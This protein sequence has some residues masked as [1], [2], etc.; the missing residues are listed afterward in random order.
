MLLSRPYSHTTTRTVSYERQSLQRFGHHS[1]TGQQEP[2]V[3]PPGHR[4]PPGPARAGLCPKGRESPS[5]PIQMLLPP[6]RSKT[7]THSLLNSLCLFCRGSFSPGIVVF[8]ISKEPLQSGTVVVS[9][10][11]ELWISFLCCDATAYPRE[12][13]IVRALSRTAAASVAAAFFRS[14]GSCVLIQWCVVRLSFVSR[15]LVVYAGVICLGESRVL[16]LSLDGTFS[17]HGCRALPCLVLVRR[18][19]DFCYG[20]TVGS[21]RRE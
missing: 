16:E 8:S 10:C 12:D 11:K 9:I 17:Q 6:P 14:G 15:S 19:R 3:R 20:C 13:A 2:S 21:A 18:R 5:C 7:R 1:P 4:P